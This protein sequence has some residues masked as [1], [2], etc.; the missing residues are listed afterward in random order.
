MHKKNFDNWN[1]V[2]IK[3]EL[4][5]SVFCRIWEVWMANIWENIWDEENWKWNQ[6]LRPVFIV[7]K[8]NNNIFLWVPM[9]SKIKENKFHFKIKTNIKW[10]LVLSQMRLFSS[11]RLDYRIFV[12]SYEIT[13]QIKQKLAELISE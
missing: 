3:T 7:K 9:T 12:V 6:S 10:C 11:K 4:K 8:F 5:K 13:K 1:E 2:K